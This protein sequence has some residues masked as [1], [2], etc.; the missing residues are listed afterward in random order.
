MGGLPMDV[1]RKASF[2]QC[3]D[4]STEVAVLEPVQYF[5]VKADLT[6]CG[7]RSNDKEALSE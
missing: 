3:S 2:F 7:G 1:S 5:L 4:D 6:D